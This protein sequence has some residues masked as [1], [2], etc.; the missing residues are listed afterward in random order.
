MATVTWIGAQGDVPGSKVYTI[1]AGSG[2]TFTAKH[3]NK[4]AT[5]LSTGSDTATTIAAAIVNAMLASPFG[6]IQELTPSNVAGVITVLGPSDGAPDTFTLTAAGGAGSVSAPTTVAP[7]SSH[8]ASDGVNYSTGAL[9]G[10]ADTLVFENSAVD[11]LYNLTALAALTLTKVIRRT[12]YTGQVGLTRQSKRGYQEFRGRYLQTDAVTV[13][14]D[15]SADDAGFN[16]E[17]K[18][19]L[20]STLAGTSTWIVT[21][22][23]PGRIG[24]EIVDTYGQA[25]SSVLDVTGAGV[26]VAR[27]AG[28]T[29][30]FVSVL[31]ANC[32]LTL[33]PG[34]TLTA[35]AFVNVT[36]VVQANYTTLVLDGGGQVTTKD[37]V[38]AATSSKVQAGTVIWQSTGTPAALTVGSDGTF[39]AGTAPA[40]FVVGSVA[41]VGDGY[42]FLDPN[43][44]VTRGT[45]V[46]TFTGTSLTKGT[47][48]LGT[49]GTMTLTS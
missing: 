11:V 6:E 4:T 43:K 19:F 15:T 41:F 48:D 2:T 36:A 30:T 28:Q 38:A 10:A 8:D 34:C 44:R 23:T 26:S 25:G 22:P 33:G 46:F 32:A 24:S 35:L 1:T 18:F 5:Y 45:L 29:A 42:T 17:A 37:A 9:P 7:K 49:E 21:G 39:D 3:N 31:G 40:A 16:N 14:W 12:S 47:L 13:Q 27:F 20:Q